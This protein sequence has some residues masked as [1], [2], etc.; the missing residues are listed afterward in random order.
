M[1]HFAEAKGPA[2]RLCQWF[3]VALM[4]SVLALNGKPAQ[5]SPLNLELQT[6]PDLMSDFI[7]VSYD[8]NSQRLTVRGGV[9]SPD[10][11]VSQS[12]PIINGSFEITAT[13][14]AT[15]TFTSGTITVTGEVPSLGIAKSVLL[16][17]DLNSLGYGD[18]G[19]VVEFLFNT[20]GGSF[21]DNFGPITGVILGQ[22]GFTGD[23]TRDFSSNSVAVA[24]ISK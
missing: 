10:D 18:A 21:A 4:L 2:K 12:T 11:K 7:N 15:G 19:G 3:T 20:S 8:A 9:E 16:S 6:S 24:S 1:L 13:I 5:A 17:G 14:S 23:F 22:S